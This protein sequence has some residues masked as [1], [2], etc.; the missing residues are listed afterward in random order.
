[1]KMARKSS[2]LNA[3][4]EVLYYKA[5][6]LSF[7]EFGCFSSLSSIFEKARKRGCNFITLRNKDICLRYRIY[8]RSAKLVYNLEK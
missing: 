4:I 8:S 1:M 3:S 2:F 5:S 7:S 6:I